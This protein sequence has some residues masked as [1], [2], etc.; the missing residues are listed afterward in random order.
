MMRAANVPIDT[1]TAKKQ[2]ERINDFLEA[3]HLIIGGLAVEQYSVRRATK[4]IDLICDSSTA[5]AILDNLYPAKDWD[6]D[7]KNGDEYRPSYHITHKVKGVDSGTIILGPKI[8]ERSP[9]DNLNWE[10]LKEKARPF[11]G[12]AKKTLSNILVPMPDALAYTKLISAVN[13]VGSQGKVEQDLKDFFDL[14]DCEEFSTSR[15]YNLSRSLCTD[16]E[17][18]KL[19]HAFRERLGNYQE[20]LQRSGLFSLIELLGFENG[21]TPEVCDHLKILKAINH[22]IKATVKRN[23]FK[24]SNVQNSIEA[25][26]N[27]VRGEVDINSCCPLTK[28]FDSFF[29]VVFSAMYD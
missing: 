15:F 9:Y 18:K 17:Q 23:K 28:D 20:V 13:R 29:D 25:I 8:L 21:A 5:K 14:T 6:I 19:F 3:P 12:V 7:D 10:F 1:N 26:R 27:F 4:D 16:D 24:K 22:A 2:L 11:V